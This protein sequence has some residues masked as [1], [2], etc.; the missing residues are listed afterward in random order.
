MQLDQRTQQRRETQEVVSGPGPEPDQPATFCMK[1]G[2][3]DGLA[4][5]DVEE[6][7]PVEVADELEQPERVASEGALDPVEAALVLHGE[8]R[9]I[10]AVPR[11]RCSS[12]A[13]CSRST[14][15]SAVDCFIVICRSCSGSPSLAR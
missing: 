6:E 12:A 14:A 15:P 7:R 5:V 9:T 8:A 4:P 2:E 13:R 3:A 11:S 1:R 10:S